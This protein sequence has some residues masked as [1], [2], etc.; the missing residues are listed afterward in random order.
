[1][2]CNWINGVII[3]TIRKEK[4]YSQNIFEVIFISLEQVLDYIDIQ[5][6]IPFSKEIYLYLNSDSTISSSKGMRK[7]SMYSTIRTTIL[8]H[9]SKNTTYSRLMST[10]LVKK[11]VIR[12]WTQKYNEKKWK[13][14]YRS[15][16]IVLAPEVG[17]G[18]H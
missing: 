7:I 14:R 15:V 5:K 6:D 9:Y 12:V 18:T 1:M 3:H 2:K 8:K 16:T 17:W 4:I 13:L 11:Y 10:R